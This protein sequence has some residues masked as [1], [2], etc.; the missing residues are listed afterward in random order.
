MIHKTILIAIIA[1]FFSACKPSNEATGGGT[2]KPQVYAVNY[3]LAYFTDRIGGKLID[4]HFPETNGDPAFWKPK[5]ADV[6]RFQ[7]ADLI[8]LNGA[9][10]AKWITKVS[11]P[12][13]RAVNTSA[14]FR[15]SFIPLENQSTHRHAKDGGHSHKGTAF[16]T[17]LDL[18]QAEQQAVAIR[19]A[20]IR[21]LPN[22]K[23]A[24]ESNFVALQKNLQALDTELKETAVK[25]VETPLTGSH[26]VYQ[27]LARAYNLKV[28]SVHWEPNKMPD[29]ADWAE[30]ATIRKKHPAKIMLW[31][32]EPNKTIARKL[33]E[34]GV[35]SVVFNPCGNRPDEGDWF[36]VI[37]ANILQLGNV[38]PEK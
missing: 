8:L 36:S 30:L 9:T 17:W 6:R 12:E 14:H 23:H 31:E 11:L 29:E 34:L 7:K 32:G 4:V 19:D 24:I 3:P 10:Y 21:L 25:F 33:L 22:S 18:K 35:S 2:D 5:A 28:R 37:Q 1:V 16:T 26:P 27:Y 15:K 38:V 13:S 20:L